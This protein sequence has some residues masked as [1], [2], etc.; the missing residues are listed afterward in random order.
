MSSTAYALVERIPLSEG[1]EAVEHSNEATLKAVLAALALQPFSAAS[2]ERYKQE[3]AKA[4]NSWLWLHRAMLGL[5]YLSVVL[6]II[7]FVFGVPCLVDSIVQQHAV[8]GVVL[9]AAVMVCVATLIALESI[10]IK[11]RAVWE[12]VPKPYYRG[13]IPAAVT[14]TLCEIEANLPKVDFVVHRLVQNR[15]VLDP[16]IEARHG[17]ESYFIAVWDE[18]YAA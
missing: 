16:F 6:C 1:P 14:L 13:R 7:V 2:V 15:K 11:N 4:A 8:Q 17:D 9:L 10:K 5:P 3:K 12:V 18:T